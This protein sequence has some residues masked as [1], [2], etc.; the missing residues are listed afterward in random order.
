[1]SFDNGNG[2]GYGKGSNSVIEPN[3]IRD[4][5]EFHATL[6]RYCLSLTGT[7]WDAED[8]VQDTWIKAMTASRSF[9]HLNPEAYLLRI[10]KNTW[11]DQARRASTLSRLL[12]SER[13]KIASPSSGNLELESAF[14]A[15][16]QHLSPLQRAVFLL[17]Q[18]LDYSITETAEKLRTTEGAVK[19]ALHRARLALNAVRDDIEKGL[20]LPDDSGVQSLLRRLAEAYQLGDVTTLIALVQHSEMEPAMAIG[21]LQNR[22]LRTVGATTCRRSLN[23]SSPPLSPTMRMAA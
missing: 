17:R 22:R 8:L 16:L 10:A 20:S 4:N 21:L 6:K 13:P 14:Q 7:V 15:L 9:N 11:I 23:P 12:R 3:E 1:M 2:I 19:A 18:V 5:P